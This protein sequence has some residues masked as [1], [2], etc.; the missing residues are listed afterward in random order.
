V[1]EEILFRKGG[2]ECGEDDVWVFRRDGE[3]ATKVASGDDI[4]VRGVKVKLAVRWVATDGEL[5]L[6]AYTHQIFVNGVKGTDVVVSGVP[7]INPTATIYVGSNGDDSWGDARIRELD[8]SPLVLLDE[9]LARR[10]S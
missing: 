9:E 6:Q 10:P 5:E 1:T 7:A 4:P 3:E 8:F 2:N